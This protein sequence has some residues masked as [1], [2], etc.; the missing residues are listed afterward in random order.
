V[1]RQATPEDAVA[2]AR[3]MI[4]VRRC[5]NPD[6]ADAAGEP[7]N[8]IL[9]PIVA[10]VDCTV[11]GTPVW[12]S[13]VL[14]LHEAF[15]PEGSNQEVLGRALSA[16]EHLV[17]AGVALTIL[18]DAPTMLPECAFIVDGPL[19][20]FGETAPLRL[21]LL[22]V[23]RYIAGKLTENELGLPVVVGIEK[24]G[25]AVD[26]LRAL[27]ERIPAGTLIACRTPI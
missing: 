13:D 26:H 18:D 19:A 12:S 7:A 27:R 1:Q 2:A 25:Y 6:C 11:C 5:P 21:G 20:K 17:V 22:G 23:W 10:S 16:I 15:N 24:T 4:R 9:V 3:D 8:D 14:R